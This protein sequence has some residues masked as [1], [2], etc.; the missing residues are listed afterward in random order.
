MHVRSLRSYLAI[1]FQ[2]TVADCLLPS[3]NRRFR[4]L[5]LLTMSPTSSAYAGKRKL[6]VFALEENLCSFV[7][8]RSLS[9]SWIRFWSTIEE[10]ICKLVSYY[11]VILFIYRLE[12]I[13]NCYNWRSYDFLFLSSNITVV[14]CY[15][16]DHFF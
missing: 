4:N 8:V 16:H 7:C 5:C 14:Y 15:N 1:K 13:C 10:S 9:S 6:L 11:D 3:L 2:A 12:V